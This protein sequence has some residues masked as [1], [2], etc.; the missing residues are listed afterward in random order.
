MT[1]A[2]RGPMLPEW[3]RGLTRRDFS[4]DGG[5]CPSDAIWND[6]DWSRAYMDM[7]PSIAGNLGPY[8]HVPLR[9]LAND[10]GT[11]HRL[12]PM[13][14]KD[15]WLPL[16]RR[17]VEEARAFFGAVD[18][19]LS[20]H[21]LSGEIILDAIA[22]ARKEGEAKGR[23]KERERWERDALRYRY[24]RDELSPED[25]AMIDAAELDAFIDAEMVAA[26]NE[27]EDLI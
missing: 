5:P 1:E 24:I 16:I 7:G 11:A 8:W 20:S 14:L 13:V 17:A 25:F 26:R 27:R 12:Y 22:L 4:F 3:L 18:G 19:V 23:A 2:E 15:K 6:L 10:Y 21:P 9:E